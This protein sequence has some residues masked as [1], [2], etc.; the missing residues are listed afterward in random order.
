VAR[1]LNLPYRPARRRLLSEKSLH[2]TIQSL[3]NVVMAFQLTIAQLHAI[4]L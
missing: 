2:S 4:R 1:H 3:F